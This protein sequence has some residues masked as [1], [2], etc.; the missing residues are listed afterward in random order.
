MRFER[1]HAER[2]AQIKRRLTGQ[3][4]DRLMAQMD[5]VKISDGRSRATI[6]GV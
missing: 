1:H 6:I 4:Y 2:R 3:I 5:A